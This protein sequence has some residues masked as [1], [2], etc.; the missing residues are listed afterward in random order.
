VFFDLPHQKEE[1]DDLIILLRNLNW[2]S[3]ILEIKYLRSIETI[4]KAQEKYKE[5]KKWTSFK[6]TLHFLGNDSQKIGCLL[7][8][9]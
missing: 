3:R 9:V 8:K 4:D 7:Q 1:E 6:S 2:M 5:I